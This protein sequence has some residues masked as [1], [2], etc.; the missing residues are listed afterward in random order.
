MPIKYF[1]YPQNKVNFEECLI[2]NCW[3][4]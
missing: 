3:I 1:L 4:K 2:W